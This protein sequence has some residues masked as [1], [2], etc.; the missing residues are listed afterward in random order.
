MTHPDF[1][2]ASTRRRDAALRHWEVLG[3]VVGSLLLASVLTVKAGIAQAEEP[4][5]TPAFDETLFK[6]GAVRMREQQFEDWHLKCQE[7][8]KLRQRVCNLLSTLRDVQGQ[9]RGSALVATNE[10]GVPTMLIAVE[11]PI[12]Q[13]R[14]IVIESIFETP[15]RNKKPV[16]VRYKRSVKV[17]RCDTN[18]KFIFPFE[19]NLAL[20]LNSG[21]NLSVK[22]SVPTTTSIVPAQT[23][24]TAKGAKKDLRLVVSANGFAEALKASLQAWDP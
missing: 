17:A 8:V 15:G 4:I 20:A 6:D 19:T 7:V 2:D 9:Q 14:P 12:R 1:A 5:A 13:E 24:K 18:C 11:V 22:A 3:N 21:S 10:T 16:K 23:S